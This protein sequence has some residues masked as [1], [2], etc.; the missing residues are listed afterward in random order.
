MSD[1][2]DYFET[3]ML[4]P[5]FA[6]EYERLQPQYEIMRAIISA[7]I[8]QGLTQEELAKKSGLRQVNIRR[9]EQGTC[10]PTLSTL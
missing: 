2:R 10:N 8:E 4:N 5:D 6:A 9:L 7:Q 1:L 3:Q